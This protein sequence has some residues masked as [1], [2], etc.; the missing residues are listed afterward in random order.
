MLVT[1]AVR[2]IL[3]KVN[4]PEPRLLKSEISAPSSLRCVIEPHWIIRIRRFRLLFLF[5]EIPGGISV[6]RDDRGA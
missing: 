6:K 2:L 3:E 4:R 1:A 5:V